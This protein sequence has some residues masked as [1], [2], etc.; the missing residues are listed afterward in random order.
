M[1]ELRKNIYGHRRDTAEH[2]LSL[3]EYV[4]RDDEFTNVCMD[5]K[6][7]ALY[8]RRIQLLTEVLQTIDDTLH[9]Y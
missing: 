8:Y 4:G 3:A 7:R 2:L 9:D 1:I 5:R 6:M